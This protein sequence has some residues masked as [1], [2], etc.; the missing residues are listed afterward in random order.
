MTTTTQSAPTFKLVRAS[1]FHKILIT[2]SAVTLVQGTASAVALTVSNPSF[3]TP[4]LGCAPSSGC[5][6]FGMGSPWAVGSAIGSV[7]TFRPG[8]G[9][10]G[11]VNFIPDGSQVAAVGNGATFSGLITQD[12]PDILAADTTYTLSF[13]VGSR[14]EFITFAPYTVSLK[15]GGV[16]L[17]QDSGANPAPGDFVLRT[18]AFNSGSAPAQLGQSFRIEVFESAGGQALFDG[19]GLDGT[20]T[21]A[22]P[23]P[24]TSFLAG[25]GLLI[26]MATLKRKASS[27]LPNHD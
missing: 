24:S 4:L 10:G 20:N 16:L 15:A 22:T 27:L 25:T 7:A 21:S 1:I 14:A 13:Y 19:F 8:V 3:E 11:S 12:L 2:I 26:F 9:V 23:E 18:L 5:F 17:A 6:Q